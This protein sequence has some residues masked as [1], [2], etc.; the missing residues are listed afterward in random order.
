MMAAIFEGGVV[1]AVSRFECMRVD[2]TNQSDPAVKAA[3][4]KFD[5]KGY[6]TVIL[7]DASGSTAARIVGFVDSTEMLQRIDSVK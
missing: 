7:I 4:R 1:K 5:V 3:E 6:P 2:G